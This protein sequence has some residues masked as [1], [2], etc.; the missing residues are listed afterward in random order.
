MPIGRVEIQIEIWKGRCTANKDTFRELTLGQ[1]E[2]KTKDQRSKHETILSVLAVHQPFYIS[3]FIKV[4]SPNPFPFPITVNIFVFLWR[5]RSY[6]W[7]GIKNCP[8]PCKR[9]NALILRIRC[10]DIWQLTQ[11]WKMLLQ[12]DKEFIF[13]HKD[14]DPPANGNLKNVFSADIETTST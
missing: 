13:I 5:R 3:I 1:R 7:W 10:Q 2:A 14:Y 6:E 9:L 12:T 11:W 4:I 8:Q